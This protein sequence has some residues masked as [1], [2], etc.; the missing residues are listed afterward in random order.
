MLELL[1]RTT[2][3]RTSSN[4]NPNGQA[5]W[6][7]KSARNLSQ[8]VFLFRRLPGIRPFKNFGSSNDK[9]KR[10]SNRTAKP[11]RGSSSNRTE[12]SNRTNGQATTDGQRAT[13][14]ERPSNRR[15]TIRTAKPANDADAA[16]VTRDNR[17]T[18]LEQ[19]TETTERTAENRESP[20]TA[21]ASS[22]KPTDYRPPIG[23]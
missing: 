12:T 20:T 10:A 18:I 17:P 15:P 3:D 14:A 4:G 16:P 11:R 6:S 13:I 23:R 2:N 7:S 22:S 19:R 9:R 21:K 5:S 1:Q 8:L